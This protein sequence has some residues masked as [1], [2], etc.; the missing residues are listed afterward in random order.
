MER[1]TP[2]QVAERTKKHL[3]NVYVAIRNKRLKKVYVRGKGLRQEVRI[4]LTEDNERV[5]QAMLEES[6]RGYNNGRKS[7]DNR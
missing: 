7:S 5:I 2:Q 4:P 1:L 3:T 6:E